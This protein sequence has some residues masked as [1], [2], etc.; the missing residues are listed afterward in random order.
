MHRSRSGVV[1]AS[2]ALAACSGLRDQS[3]AS[4]KLAGKSPVPESS[5]ECSPYVDPLKGQEWT[6]ED[7]VAKNWPAYAARFGCTCASEPHT[8]NDSSAC[9]PFPCT[10][11]G[12]YVARCRVDTDCAV[13]ICAHYSG[14]PHDACVVNDDK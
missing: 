4:P 6:T 8:L 12:C 11:T 2:L 7:M 5:H 10:S 1:V 14:F 3:P 9:G 13:G